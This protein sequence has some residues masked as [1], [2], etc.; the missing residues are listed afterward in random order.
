MLIHALMKNA[1][2]DT[3]IYLCFYKIFIENKNFAKP[4]TCGVWLSNKNFLT[5]INYQEKRKEGR[6]F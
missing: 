5:G 2:L 6:F 3:L 4:S 1:K